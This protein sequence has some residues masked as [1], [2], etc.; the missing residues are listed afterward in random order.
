MLVTTKAVLLRSCKAPVRL[1]CGPNW[2]MQVQTL[3]GKA[4]RAP[5]VTKTRCLQLLG[6]PL[7]ALQGLQQTGAL[8]QPPPTNQP[9]SVMLLPQ[10]RR[11]PLGRQQAQHISL[12]HSLQTRLLPLPCTP[13]ASTGHRQRKALSLHLDPSLPYRLSTSLRCLALPRVPA[14]QLPAVS[15]QDQITSTQQ[16]RPKSSQTWLHHPVRGAMSSLSPGRKARLLSQARGLC[17]CQEHCCRALLGHTSQPALLL[18][19]MKA[20]QAAQS[21]V[22][23]PRPPLQRKLLDQPKG[24]HLILHRLL[25][26][27]IV[28]QPGQ[29]SKSSQQ[30]L[31]RE[32][33]SWLRRYR[34]D[35][36]HTMHFPAAIS[37]LVLLN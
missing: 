18:L 27:A 6:L 20:R 29:V 10:A 36:L 26:K 30:R 15:Q 5:A 37:W 13:V 11:L 34:S 8:V 19:D 28:Q 24:L 21:R 33:F 17:Y 9:A 4:A 31:K 23:S 12:Q 25:H 1:S 2:T 7:R 3:A 16:Q 14:N 22:T 35:L 32:L